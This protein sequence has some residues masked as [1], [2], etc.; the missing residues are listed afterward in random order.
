VEDRSARGPDAAKLTAGAPLL[1]YDGV[2]G[3][4]AESVRVI[5][6]H[7]RRHTLLFAALQSP[8]GM[9]VRARHPELAEVDSMI[10]V[11]PP[12]RDVPERVL[13]KSDVALNIA[14]YLGGL[15][16]LAVPARLVPRFIRDV[17]YDFIARHRHQIS[18]SLDACILP[19]PETRARFLD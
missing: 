8:L 12:S 15:W 3:F 17:V 6:R 5:L 9:A 4:C 18:G 2:C 14:A 10:W 7:E 13:V 19:S 11:E 16:A 1:L